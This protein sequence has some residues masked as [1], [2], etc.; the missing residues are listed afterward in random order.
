[1]N[2]RRYR[3][4]V[5]FIFF[6][7]GT[8]IL[9]SQSFRV[10]K[11]NFENGLPDT[12]VLDVIQDTTGI[13]WF[14]ARNGI[15]SYD[16]TEWKHLDLDNET[17]AYYKFLEKDEL[18]N[19]WVLPENSDGSILFYNYSAW[20]TIPLPK[21][22]NTMDFNSFSV[23]NN[24]RERI[25]AIGSMDG[26]LIFENGRWNSFN[27]ENGL[28]NN[29]IFS[30]DVYHHKAIVLATM[31]GLALYKD[32]KISD[33]FSGL[34]FP[35]KAIFA[36]CVEHDGFDDIIW[37]LGNNWLGYIKDNKFVEVNSNFDFP[38]YNTPNEYFIIS[39]HRQ[40]IYIGN[41]ASAFWVDR[42]IGKLNILSDDNGI[43]KEG[44]TNAFVDR[45]LNVWFS[46]KRGIHKIRKST[47]VNFYKSDGLLENEVSAI[48]KFQNT[49]VLGH[50]KGLSFISGKKI[51]NLEFSAHFQNVSNRSRVLDLYNTGNFIYVAA[52]MQGIGILD[53]NFNLRWLN[54]SSAN[55]YNSISPDSSGKY[56]A[57][58]SR[59]LM[60]ITNNQVVTD[61]EFEKNFKSKQFIRR[62][63]LLSDG[64]LALSTINSGII[65]KNGKNIKQIIANEALANSTYC[66]F[67][68]S[69]TLLVGTTKGLYYK[70]GEV[71]KPY[72]AFGTL[73]DVPVYFINKDKDGHLWFGLNNGIF[74]WDK[75]HLQRF[76]VEDGLSGPETNRDA[77]FVDENGNFWVGTNK[78]LSFFTKEYSENFYIAPKVKITGLE[79][80]TGVKYNSAEEIVLNSSENN[81]WIFYRG[82]SFIEETANRFLVTLTNIETSE[83][84]KIETKETSVRFANLAPGQ[85]KIAVK[86]CNP[87]GIWS[88]KAETGIIT[89]NSPF[90]SQL[91]FFMLV[92]LF[93][94][95]IF[96][97]I[98]DTY[99]NK[100]YSRELEKKVAE[101]TMELE[102]SE[103][104]Y[105][106]L[107]ETAIDGIIS[108]DMDF[109]IITWNKAAENIYGYTPEQVL[110]RNYF[111]V[112]K[113]EIKMNNFEK[114][115]RNFFKLET[116]QGEITQCNKNNIKLNML[117]AA[118]VYKDTDGNIIGM[119]GICRDI[120]EL[121]QLE[122]NKTMAVLET[123]EKERNRISRDL[124]D[125]LGQI[126]SSAKLKLE[127]F[128]YKSSIQ[129]SF[130]NEAIELIG[131]AGKELRNIVHDLHPAEI[132]RYGLL[133]AIDLLIFQ[134][135]KLS[136]INI[137]L[138]KK[139]YSGKLK[140]KDE[141]MIYRIIQEALNNAI[142]HSKAE[143]I[144]VSME[145]A[146]GNFIVQII[147]K[148]VGF[149]PDNLKLNKEEIHGYGLLNMFQRAEMMAASL[150]INSKPGKGTEIIIKIRV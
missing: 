50:D 62:I 104:K 95:V 53:K 46:S 107:V 111:E 137:F 39:D 73:I 148:G 21:L 86:V 121:K 65:F 106:Q 38:V 129:D 45:E 142:K 130:F 25:L 18:G 116:W 12:F 6:L 64:S 44:A 10:K 141:L 33:E 59:G 47:F 8:G 9:S 55:E 68:Y 149:N 48:E 5:C 42:N 82:L 28:P 88:E 79:N 147:D 97:M 123:L 52:S 31:S 71:L 150:K 105:R 119:V 83:Y 24:D 81:I 109:N 35:G 117:I 90:Y 11:Y 77:S 134:M 110:G 91:W 84:E 140:K 144:S 15:F 56:W 3:I 127:V 29:Y 14:T 2:F 136:G 114:T 69:D 34:N 7:L 125:D 17:A 112:T 43:I 19:I 146:N 72:R 133:A 124:H 120:T 87:K 128:E 40:R 103:K 139:Q 27:T 92:I 135:Q 63:N 145:E 57:G 36:T 89:I 98:L 37:L 32:G 113:S 132:E 20:Q 96:F 118:S 41:Q 75:F 100:K 126:L 115:I 67:E 70:D 78:G 93:V 122:K 60:S 26:M 138:L 22:D 94:G 85:Y 131:H 30:T 49:L 23:I 99:S 66:V 4:L 58:S 80:N 61:E 108:T 74:R 102:K 54:T 101:R 16:A 51:W 1:L 143:I 13:M 76:G